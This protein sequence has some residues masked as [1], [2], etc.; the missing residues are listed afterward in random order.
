MLF[1]S[2][3]INIMSKTDELVIIGYSF[4]PED[5]NAFLLLSMLPQRC[6][7]TLVDPRPKEIKERL[8]NKGFKVS[9]ECLED[10]LSDRNV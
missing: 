8:E 9:R 4:R 2:S 3:A 1:R 7:I 5:S 6:D 10:Y